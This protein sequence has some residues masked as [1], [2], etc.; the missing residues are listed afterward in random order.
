[1]NWKIGVRIHRDILA[2]ARAEYGEQIVSTLSRQLT[3]EYGAGFSRQNLFHMVRFV[4]PGRM[5]FR[6]VRWHSNSGA[7]REIVARTFVLNFRGASEAMKAELTTCDLSGAWQI[8]WA[9]YRDHGVQTP[10]VVKEF[11]GVPSDYAHIRW[12]SFHSEDPYSDVVVHE[13]AHLLHYLKPAN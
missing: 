7:L 13:A 9:M 10:G 8:L 12:P 2:E 4:E 1:M 3:V 6:S 11:D 5:K